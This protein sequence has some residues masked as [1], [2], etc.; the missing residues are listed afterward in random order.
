MMSIIYKIEN[1]IEYLR[2]ISTLQE[3][4]IEY[5]ENKYSD[6][7]FPVLNA[8]EYYAEISVPEEYEES[9]NDIINNKIVDNYSKN[10][11]NEKPKKIK[12]NYLILSLIIYSLISTFLCLYFWYSNNRVFLDKNFD[13]QLNTERTIL[14]MVNEKSEKTAFLY[15]DENY[16]LNWEE[17][18]TF[19]KS[20]EQAGI[21]YDFNEDGYTDETSFYNRNQQKI[22]SLFD[23]N[24]D[25]IYDKFEV[26]I[27]DKD[28][29]KFIFNL[30]I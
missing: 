10:T 20:G 26:L 1:E 19:S 7:S 11:V 15:F 30:K 24:I 9:V 6:S 4:K 2:I 25:G 5:T 12:F 14:T 28:T 8:S 23:T 22:L 3:M 18:R 27:N 21:S 13:V 17:Y 29:T 16:D